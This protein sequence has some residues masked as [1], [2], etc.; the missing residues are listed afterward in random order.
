MTAADVADVLGRLDR[1]GLWYCVEGGWGVDAL[2]GDQTRE[3]R[4][5]DIGVRL[6]DVESMCA[7]LPEFG[8]DDAE[9][10]SSVVLED[11]AGRRVDAHP[12]TFDEAGDG[13]QA[14]LNG[15]PYRWPCEHLG[16]RGRIGVREVRCIT[17]ELQVRW[18]RH[19]DFDDVDWADMSALAS[20]FGLP[21]VGPPPGF[22]SPRRSVERTLHSRHEA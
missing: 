10:P 5:L 19:E 22:I 4:D 15:D 13:W 17:P 12:L 7:A 9:W 6:G 1:A 11:A 21:D 8:R 20:R 2:L 14:K 16:A 3:H 18:H